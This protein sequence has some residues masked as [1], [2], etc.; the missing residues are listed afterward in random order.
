MLVSGTPASISVTGGTNGLT[1][2]PG[3]AYGATPGAAGTSVTNESITQTS[4]TQSG[5]QCT[6]D[7]TLGKSTSEILLAD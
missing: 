6:P 3:V 1:V 7:M 2:N 5:A 4:G